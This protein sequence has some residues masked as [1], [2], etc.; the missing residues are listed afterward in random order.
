ML[1]RDNSP[2]YPLVRLFRQTTFSDWVGVFDRIVEALKPGNRPHLRENILLDPQLPP[3]LSPK[4]LI[5][6]V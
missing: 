4:S 5:Y 6:R 1:D 2:W 3:Y